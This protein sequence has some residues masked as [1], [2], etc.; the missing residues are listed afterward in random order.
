M[1]NPEFSSGF[2]TLLDSYSQENAITIEV[3]E[4]EKSFFL[5]QAQQALVKELYSSGSGSVAFE[6]TE[7]LRRQLESLVITAHPEQVESED[8]VK[9]SRGFIHTVYELPEHCWYIVYEEVG[10]SALNCNTVTSEVLPITHDDY[11]RVVKNPFR[12]PTSTRVLRLDKGN[13]EVELVSNF[14]I[15]DKYLIRYIKKP[16]P[17]IL[18]DLPEEAAID[19]Y[20]RETTCELPEQLH[21]EI[22]QTAVQLAI[23]R[24]TQYNSKS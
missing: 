7:Q 5:T 15:G 14:E 18:E 23:E 19:G 1:T 21:W 17:I 13:H 24:K 11:T 10:G 12:G 22:L 8:V 2:D 20:Y 4:Y 16:T 6:L 9:A 3:N